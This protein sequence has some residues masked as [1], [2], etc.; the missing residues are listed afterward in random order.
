[1]N[2]R[3]KEFYNTSILIL[4]TLLSNSWVIPAATRHEGPGETGTKNKP[5]QGRGQGKEREYQKKVL[6]NWQEKEREGERTP[7]CLLGGRRN[8]EGKDRRLRH[9]RPGS[10]VWS[11]RRPLLSRQER[12]NSKTQ[13]ISDRTQKTKNRRQ[14]NWIWMRR[15]WSWKRTGGT[16]VRWRRG[17][18]A[19]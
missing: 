3:H 4:Y 11:R 18:E 13:K 12:T 17:L 6:E 16:C 15:C 10:S 2:R 9:R 14:E 5:P 7:M 19:P 1:M 8:K